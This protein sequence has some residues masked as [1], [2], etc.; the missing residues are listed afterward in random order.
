MPVFPPRVG[1]V[2]RASH[3]VF[4]NNIHITVLSSAAPM[5]LAKGTEAEIIDVQPMHIDL[6]CKDAS[7]S[8]GPSAWGLKLR[9][10]K[11]VWGT[12]FE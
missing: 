9:V 3:D 8:S 6:T 7:P 1:Q 2:V 11:V 5:M 4:L 12:T 10:A